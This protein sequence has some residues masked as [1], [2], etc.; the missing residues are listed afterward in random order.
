MHKSEKIFSQI[1]QNR[2]IALLDPN[3]VEGC[4]TAYELVNPEG[5]VLEIALRSAP[6]LDGIRAIMEKYPEALILAGTVMTVAQAEAAVAAG[7]GGI[8]SSD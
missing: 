6:A 1:K 3:S 2:L 4:L 8:I 7:V 5:I